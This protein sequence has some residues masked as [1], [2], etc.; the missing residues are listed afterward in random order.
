MGPEVTEKLQVSLQGEQA[1]IPLLVLPCSPL[2]P[3]Q[4]AVPRNELPLGPLQALQCGGSWWRD[5]PA[6]LAFMLA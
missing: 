3:L 6:R 1:G 5:F 2:L 4:A